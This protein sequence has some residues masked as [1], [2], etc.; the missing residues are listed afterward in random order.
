MPTERPGRFPP[1][2]IKCQRHNNKEFNK[3]WQE[4]RSEQSTKLDRKQDLNDLYHV[5]VLWAYRKAKMAALTSDWLRHFLL[6]LRNRWMKF[7][8]RILK[9]EGRYQRP[10]SSFWGFFGRSENQYGCPGLWVAETVL[11]SSLQLLNRIQWKWGMVSILPSSLHIWRCS[12]RE[13]EDTNMSDGQWWWRWFNKQT[14]KFRTLPLVPSPPG[15]HP[16]RGVSGVCMCIHV[17]LVWFT[18]QTGFIVSHQLPVCRQLHT[19]S[20]AQLDSIWTW[21]NAH[22]RSNSSSPTGDRTWI[23]ILVVQCFTAY[24][25]VNGRMNL[26][27]DGQG[28]RSQWTNMEINLWM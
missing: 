11:T 19:D 26:Y 17:C 1:F 20:P 22:M 5:C 6:L 10:L 8:E 28:S 23:A 3:T 7:K 18:I 12:Y 13:K 16:A 9:E 15:P 2:Q 14:V 27:I 21:S 25:I 24:L 4:A